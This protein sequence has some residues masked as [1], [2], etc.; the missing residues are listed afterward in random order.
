MPVKALQQLTFLG[1]M[2][3]RALSRPALHHVFCFVIYFVKCEGKFTNCAYNFL[4]NYKGTV[5][6][7]CMY[8][9]QLQRQE[10]F[11]VCLQY[12]NSGR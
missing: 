5:H 9:H 8:N 7:S 3:A 6:T 12:Y 11:C 10:L 2:L 4:I 1:G